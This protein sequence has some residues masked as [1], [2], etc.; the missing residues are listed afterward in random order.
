MPRAIARRVSKGAD[1]GSKR[2]WQMMSA[3]K[4]SAPAEATSLAS[5]DRLT[6]KRCEAISSAALIPVPLAVAAVL[7]LR[8]AS[9]RAPEREGHIR[10]KVTERETERDVWGDSHGTN[11]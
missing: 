7:H 5:A 9:R 1:L 6:G 10:L 2:D 4:V 8:V 3:A 11:F